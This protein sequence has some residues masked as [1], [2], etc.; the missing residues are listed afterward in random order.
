MGSRILRGIA[1]VIGL[2][3]VVTSTLVTFGTGLVVLAVLGVVHRSR[4][5]KGRPLTLLQSWLTA[6]VTMSVI[7]AAGFAMLFAHRD[8][9]GKAA[10]ESIIA[11]IDS[12]RPAPQPPPRLL[13]YL[14]G[15]SFQPV[16]LPKGANVA[17]L[18]FGFFMMT[19]MFGG[20]LGSLIWGSIWVLVS[21]WTGRLAG[22]DPAAH[23]P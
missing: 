19:E 15:A 5:R 1:V 18:I 17:F 7:V 10:W 22:V 21:G 14:P 13:R 20:V 12:E 4:R 8:H 11:S 16:R 23:P 6:V 3:G 9:T 2:V